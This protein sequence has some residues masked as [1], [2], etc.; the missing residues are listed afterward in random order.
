MGDD[1]SD[2]AAVPVPTPPSGDVVED[3]VR[4]RL[5][6]RL[7]GQ[8]AKAVTI[9][10][11]RVLERIGAGSMG[12]VFKA[13]DDELDRVVALKQLTLLDGAVE[14][15]LAERLRKRVLS[16]AQAL[17]ALSHPNV[18]GVFDVND[19]DDGHITIAMEFVDGHPLD[20]WRSEETT[21]AEIVAAYRQAAQGL[22]AAHAV[23][24]VHR[25]F[26]PANA[27]MGTDGRVRVLDFG[28][29]RP[30]Q[31]PSRARSQPAGA[32]ATRDSS[33]ARAAPS[34]GPSAELGTYATGV[35]GTPR[36]MAPEQHRGETA[37]AATDQYN[38][39]ASL[40]EALSG[41]PPFVPSAAASLE[42]AK[43][44]RA[45][46]PLPADVPEFVVQALRQGLAPSADERF[47][48]IDGLLQALRG[49]RRKSPRWVIAGA[50]GAA[51]LA[52]VAWWTQDPPRV[53]DD[54]DLPSEVWSAQ[55]QANLASAFEQTGRPYAGATWHS[56]QAHLNGWVERWNETKKARCNAYL[57][58]RESAQ[59]LDA[60]TLCL[61]ERRRALAALLAVFESAD[62]AVV[63]RALEAA[64]E[65][66]AIAPCENPSVVPDVGTPADAPTLERWRDAL[67]AA[68]ANLDAGRY[69][70]ALEQT[71]ALL[72][73]YKA[74]TIDAEAIRVT[75]LVLR[76]D[77]RSRLA[78]HE[79]AAADLEAGALAASVI[80]ADEDIVRA[81]AALIWE[82]GEVHGDFERALEWA[83]RAE[84][85]LDRGELG[86]RLRSSFHTSLGA[87]LSRKGDFDA[88][89]AEHHRALAISIEA[90]GEDD[91]LVSIPLLNI[92]NVYSMRGE[93]DRALSQYERSIE[94]MIA[95]RGAEHP[96]TL[97]ARANWVGLMASL[98]R[99]DQARAEAFAVPK[100]VAATLGED[101][102]DRA[103]ALTNLAK[104]LT[105]N[106]EP[107]LALVHAREAERIFID[108]HG[109]ASRYLLDPLSV[110][111][112]ALLH[113][114]RAEEARAPAERALVICETTFGSEHVDTGRL[115]LTL[116]DVAITSERKAPARRHLE[117]ARKIFEQQGATKLLERT[118][119]QEVRLA[120]LE[121]PVRSATRSD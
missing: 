68:H 117:R 102:P 90:W 17:A 59:R 12:V 1:S 14:P 48:S 35:V 116:A 94:L 91:G 101:H 4:G 77:A 96:V 92:G 112:F 76:G 84:A 15:A 40:W 85:V 93:I 31:R 95:T 108:N 3:V 8:R 72:D 44:I 98:G 104:L 30:V 81:A 6:A 45:L 56:V 53:C 5:R 46:S 60:S 18:V 82:H 36:Y 43:A 106:E 114:D 27:I 119:V 62:P 25:D 80:G 24:I 86:P 115:L 97:R 10:R 28:L 19:G 109:A 49:P 64:H 39:C 38:F 26:K 61:T 89:L 63:D 110:Q 2:E 111:S 51:A 58:D 120:L 57:H 66:P 99:F 74:E 37:T 113:L 83:G 41:V 107:Q 79:G 9:G 22:A 13:H 29:A 11:Y 55:R 20:Q 34:G 100:A 69:Q 16:E 23:G 54:G 103:S 87:A 33:A 121:N 105:D 32:T 71:N 78:D 70:R 47:V 75:A 73:D 21:S 7:F 88:A 118:R 42:E 65:L 67:A 52:G 50:I